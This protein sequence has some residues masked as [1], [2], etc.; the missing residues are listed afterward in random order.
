ML[1]NP[2][3]RIA[4]APAG[5][6][7][8]ITFSVVLEL[9]AEPT[10]LPSG[11]MTVRI[12]SATSSAVA[13][14]HVIEKVNWASIVVYAPAGTMTCVEWLSNCPADSVLQ[15]LDALLPMGIVP[16]QLSLAVCPAVVGTVTVP[17]GG[18]DADALAMPT[19]TAIASAMI[20]KTRERI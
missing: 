2:H 13:G 17:D 3:A 7:C 20:R 6:L 19:T 11:P 18:F 15:E 8:A 10:T 16:V 5:R 14:V 4:Y 9:S 1:T 12:S